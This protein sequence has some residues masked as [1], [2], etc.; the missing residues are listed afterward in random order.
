MDDP[1]VVRVAG[2]AKF[3]G[4]PKISRGQLAIEITARHDR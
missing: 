1:V 4:V 3:Q 2:E